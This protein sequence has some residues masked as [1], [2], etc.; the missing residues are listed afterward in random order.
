M[1]SVAR[2]ENRIPFLMEQLATVGGEAP[3]VEEKLRL[4]QEIRTYSRDIGQR[5]DQFLIE[6]LSTSQTG[7]AEARVNQDKLRELLDTLTAPPLHPAVFL[8][9]VPTEMGT[10]AMITWGSS[11]RV[12]RISE[13]VEVSSLQPGEEVLLGNE[14]N[15]IVGKSPYHFFHSGETAS[16]DRYTPDR[17]IVLKWR[18][19]EII[20]DVAGSLQGCELRSGDQVRWDRNLWMAFEKIERSERT[21]LFIED[22]PAEGFENIGGLDKE[23]EGLQRSIRL[24]LQHAETVRRYR[25]RPKG[26]VLLVGPPGT[27]K[28]MLARALANWLGQISSRGRARFMNIK[29]AGLHSMWYSQ[30]EANYRE[31][32]RIARAAGEQEPEVPVVM[33]FDEVDAIGGARGGSLVSVNDQVLTAF[34]T[35]LDGLETR[36][37]ILIVAATNRR[38]AIDPALLRPGRL[39]DAIIEL[40]RPNMKAAREIF[41]KHLRPEVPYAAANGADRD[42][43]GLRQTIIESAVS[44]IYSP[45]SDN[46]LATITFRDGKRRSVRGADLINGASIAKIALAATESACLREVEGGLPGIQLVDV[47]SAIAEDFESAAQTLTPANCHQYLSDLPQDID[48]VRVEVVRRKV[49]RPHLYLTAA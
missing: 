21:D 17:R 33:F 28:T 15:V 35:E 38:D 26:S 8:G 37:N 36:G 9:L 27:G 30:S 16:F 46:E 41:G 12:V 18:D 40:R 6:R 39:G 29:P 23:I 10:A 14:L 3:T 24:H 1:T 11:R 7:L 20:V 43:A 47:L 49:P 34:M 25:L 22:T 5:V 31:A 48:V 42:Q 44:T 45:N 13:D 32:F 19:E 4:L 2:N